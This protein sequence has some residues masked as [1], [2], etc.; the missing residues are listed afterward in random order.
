MAINFPNNPTLGQIYSFGE[1]IYKWN[2]KKWITGPIENNSL[3]S[4]EFTDY[5]LISVSSDS[6]SLDT[7]IYNFFECD[8]DNTYSNYNIT[9][10]STIGTD[11][12]IFKLNIASGSTFSISWPIGVTWAEKNPPTITENTAIIIEFYK[13]DGTLIADTIYNG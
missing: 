4:S 1:K 5:N 6:I 13:F 11:N 8:L 12:F 10:N 2:G 7:R 9:I 3:I